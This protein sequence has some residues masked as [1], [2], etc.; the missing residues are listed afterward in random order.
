MRVRS[1]DAEVAGRGG[2]RSASPVRPGADA[3]RGERRMGRDYDGR[4]G[5]R[6]EETAVRASATSDGGR[7]RAGAEVSR[8]WPGG[9]GIRAHTASR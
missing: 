7:K 3:G 6:A 5:P 8:R 2:P 4:I 1:P 9:V